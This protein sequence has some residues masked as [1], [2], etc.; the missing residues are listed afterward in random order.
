MIRNLTSLRFVFVM[1][2]FMSHFLGSVHRGYFDFGGECG[3]AFFFILSGFVMSV[4]YGE[5]VADGRFATLPFFRR[6]L[7]RL[8]PL[9]LFALTAMLALD[10]RMGIEP[11]PLPLVAHVLLIQT[12]IPSDQ[13]IFFGNGASWFLCD[14]LFFYLVFAWLYKWSMRSST[15]RL[16]AV[17]LVVAAVYFPLAVF[18]PKSYMNCLLYSNPLLRMIDFSLGIIAFRLYRSDAG[19]V[20]RRWLDER[21]PAVSTMLELAVVLSWVG[22]YFL[23]EQTD[24]MLRCSS[25]LWAPMFLAVWFFA[26]ADG[27]GGLITR[28]L[29]TRPLQ[30]LGRISFEFY[31]LHL[32]VFRIVL[33]MV[34]AWIPDFGHVAGIADILTDGRYLVLLAID[35]VVSIAVSHAASIALKHLTLNVKRQ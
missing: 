3:V 7:R 9:H 21:G 17:A 15:R 28:L 16:V 18:L 4:G 25:L 5:K 33:H 10:W 12:W 13:F 23:Y 24:A 8:Y 29:H 31:M 22:L 19:K 20:V 30:S 34:V 26:S 2:V 11:K 14:I 6:H 1:F 32:L 27:R 35:F